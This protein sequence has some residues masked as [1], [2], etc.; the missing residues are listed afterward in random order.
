VIL[1]ISAK[2]ADTPRAPFQESKQNKRTCPAALFIR[3]AVV[4]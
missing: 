2:Q 1:G 4:G 3:S